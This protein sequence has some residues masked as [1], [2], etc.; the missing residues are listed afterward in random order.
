MRYMLDTNIVSDLIRQPRGDA[1]QRLKQ[2]PASY[3]SIS[4]FVVG[5][6]HFGLL[7]K[8]ATMQRARFDEL[9]ARISVAP[10]EQPA[11]QAYAEVRLAVERQGK[12]IGANDLWIAAHAL[13]LDATLVT[14]NER[15][16]RR[17]PGLRVENWLRPADT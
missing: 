3:V 2:V 13:A 8:Q 14:A 4:V 17:V 9:L 1:A 15:E 10:F 7:R 6:V 16:F 5:E 11:E 12:P